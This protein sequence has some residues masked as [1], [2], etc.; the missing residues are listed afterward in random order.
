MSQRQ[1]CDWLWAVQGPAAR[2]KTPA[3]HPSPCHLP[4]PLSHLSSHSVRLSVLCHMSLQWACVIRRVRSFFSAELT[5]TCNSLHGPAWMRAQDQVLGPS[6]TSCPA[7]LS[8]VVLPD[9]S[10][11]PGEVR[12]GRRNL[13]ARIGSGTQTNSLYKS[14]I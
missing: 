5:R 4:W 14:S 2:P 1:P 9:E 3:A 13:G 8:G 11:S 10:P 12:G 7:A 6:L